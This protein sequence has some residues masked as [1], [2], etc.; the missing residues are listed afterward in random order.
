MNSDAVRAVFDRQMRRETPG[1][2]PGVRVERAGDVVRQ[3]GGGGDWNG[4]LWSGLGE[5]GADADAVIAAQ[6]KHFGALGLEFEWKLYS[7]DTPHDLGARLAAAGFEAEPA[8]A[9]M[10]A[11]VAELPTEVR[12]PEGVRLVPVTDAA[13][14]RLMGEAHDEAFGSDSSRIQHQVLT[15]LEADPEGLVA[16]LAMAGDRP[17]CAARIEFQTGTDF[18]SLWGGGTAPEWRGKGIYRALVAYRAAIAAERGYR[19]L[20]VDATDD[21]RP[22]LERLGFTR[23]STTTPYVYGA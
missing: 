4:V 11:E 17:V 19:Y 22:I 21:S 1:D 18:A 3:T 9:L 20:Q 6:V 7:H 12:L 10:V 13:G 16:V 14:V 2:G 15:R 8:E 23:L 5:D